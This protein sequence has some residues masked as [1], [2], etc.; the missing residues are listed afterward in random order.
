VPFEA[1]LTLI[2]AFQDTWESSMISCFASV[3][4]STT[5]ILE[6]CVDERFKQYDRLLGDIRYARLYVSQLQLHVD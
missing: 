5:K 2:K 3:V 6:Q 1:K 4:E